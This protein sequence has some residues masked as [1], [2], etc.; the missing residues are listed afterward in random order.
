M[1]TSSMLRALQAML[2]IIAIC[3]IGVLAMGFG[4]GLGANAAGLLQGR[5]AT[6][7]PV[8]AFMGNRLEESRNNLEQVYESLL[9]RLDSIPRAKLSDAQRK[10]QSYSL[11]ECEFSANYSAE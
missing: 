2:L 11:A 1:K 6:G 3:T 5:V 10:W 9:H 7:N 4:P 8:Q